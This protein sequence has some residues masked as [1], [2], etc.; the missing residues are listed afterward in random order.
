MHIGGCAM[1]HRMAAIGRA[2]PPHFSFERTRQKS[3]TSQGD[4]MMAAVQAGAFA[5]V[6]ELVSAGS[7]DL[8]YR[9]ASGL[10]P[11][12]AACRAGHAECMEALITAGCDT[13]AADKNGITGLMAGWRAASYSVLDLRPGLTFHAPREKDTTIHSS[14]A[15]QLGMAPTLLLRR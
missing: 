14:E 13:A 9:D 10:T 15:S 2:S 5:R 8:E 4:E 1:A 6:Q 7:V 3:M 11:F 12:M